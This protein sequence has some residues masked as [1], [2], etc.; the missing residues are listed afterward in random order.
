M[1]KTL[2]LWRCAKCGSMR[3][4]FA[5]TPEDVF[6][7]VPKGSGEEAPPTWIPMPGGMAHL[8]WNKTKDLQGHRVWVVCPCELV[9]LMGKEAEE[10]ELL[11]PNVHVEGQ[12]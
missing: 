12:D 2:V 6:T 10:W 5:L 1:T 9:V 3:R 8:C 7:P 11:T 4:T